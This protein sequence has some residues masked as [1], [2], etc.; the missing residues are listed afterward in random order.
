MG[1]KEWDWI[2]SLGSGH[3]DTEGEIDCI[4][5]SCGES[6]QDCI[7]REEKSTF[8]YSPSSFWGGDY[9]YN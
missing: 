7:M 2:A 3:A 6:D 9:G 8:G 5:V 1:A 4:V